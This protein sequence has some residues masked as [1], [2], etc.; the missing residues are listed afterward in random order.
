MTDLIY[1]IKDSKIPNQFFLMFVW[2]C[3]SE[4]FNFKNN[5]KLP[6][7]KRAVVLL[8]RALILIL[9]LYNYKMNKWD[10]QCNRL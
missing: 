6:I 9:I 5:N 8:L 4:K 1:E 7:L 10:A 2:N 3:K